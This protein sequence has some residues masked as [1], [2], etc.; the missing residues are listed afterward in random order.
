MTLAVVYDPLFISNNRIQFRARYTVHLISRL[1]YNSRALDIR[2][3]FFFT[4]FDY[5]DPYHNTSIVQL[6][7]IFVRCVFL[8]LSFFTRV[9]EAEMP[10]SIERCCRNPYSRLIYQNWPAAAD[11][12][13]YNNTTHIIGIS[14]QICI[15]INIYIYIYKTLQLQRAVRFPWNNSL[16]L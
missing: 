15:D 1:K 16:S 4:S 10:T 5:T 8:H 14:M 2:R 3:V 9:R 12:V 7:K 11:A 13:V 6:V